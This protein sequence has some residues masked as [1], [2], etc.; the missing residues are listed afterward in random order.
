M[1]LLGRARIKILFARINLAKMF[2]K[3]DLFVF[4]FYGFS[5]LPKMFCNE[6]FVFFFVL[7]FVF[8]ITRFFK[9]IVCILGILIRIVI[10]SRN[11]NYN[12]Y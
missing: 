12:S 7:C 9:K 6:V 1:D 4:L 5:C 3:I 10:F 11:K 2:S 8:K